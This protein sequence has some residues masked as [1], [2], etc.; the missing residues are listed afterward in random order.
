MS[1][2]QN[3]GILLRLLHADLT[4]RVRSYGEESTPIRGQQS[5]GIHGLTKNNMLTADTART[6]HGNEERLGYGV[7]QN[8]ER[9]EIIDLDA[10]LFTDDMSNWPDFL[11]LLDLSGPMASFSRNP[12]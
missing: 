2:D 1:Q 10:N 8:F 3:L 4:A 9:S 12:I 11:E 7:T 5:D 6:T